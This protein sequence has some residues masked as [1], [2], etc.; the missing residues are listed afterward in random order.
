MIM[1]NRVSFYRSAEIR[2]ENRMLAASTYNLAKILYQHREGEAL[3]IPIRSML[4]LAVMDDEEIFFLDGAVSRH[5]IVL[6]WQNFHPQR[7]AHLKASIPFEVVFYTPS[8]F[9]AM[10]RLQGEFHR[11]LL[12][13]KEREATCGEG[14]VIPLK[15]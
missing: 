1:E 3:F 14:K 6:A 11:A 12:Q 10:H 5:Q 2:R 4:F 7:R 9:E 8:A 15:K 13:L